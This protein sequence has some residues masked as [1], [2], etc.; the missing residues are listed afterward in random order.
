MSIIRADCSEKPDGD[1]AI[2][3]VVSEGVVLVTGLVSVLA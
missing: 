2:V 3:F 1:G